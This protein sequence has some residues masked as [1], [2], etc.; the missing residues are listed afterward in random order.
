MDFMVISSVLIVMEAVVRVV[1]DLQPQVASGHLAL[2]G[3]H[4]SHSIEIE[5]HN[6]EN[7]N[8]SRVANILSFASQVIKF[9]DKPLNADGSHILSSFL[10]IFWPIP[11]F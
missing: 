9:A 2:I 1:A 8:I 5:W 3:K 6:V 11:G 7:P 4:I 10:S